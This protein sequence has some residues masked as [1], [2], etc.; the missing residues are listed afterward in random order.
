MKT[1]QQ[2]KKEILAKVTEV[3]RRQHKALATERAYVG[4]IARYFDYCLDLPRGLAAESRDWE[5]GR[6]GDWEKRRL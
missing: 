6:L 2:L 1:P 3:I 5:T 4:W